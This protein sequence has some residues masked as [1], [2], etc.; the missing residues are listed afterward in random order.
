MGFSEARFDSKPI[1]GKCSRRKRPSLKNCHS[2]PLKPRRLKSRE[3]GV[4]SALPTR[5]RRQPFPSPRV[6]FGGHTESRF[7]RATW[8]IQ[9]AL[10][11]WGAGRFSCGICGRGTGS[12]KVGKWW[13]ERNSRWVGRVSF[14]KGAAEGIEAARGSARNYSLFGLDRGRPDCRCR[15]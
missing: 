14:P 4:E 5:H 13:I 7:T 6:P 11:M 1:S 2:D 15:R 10:R 8:I 12:G 3:V 9:N